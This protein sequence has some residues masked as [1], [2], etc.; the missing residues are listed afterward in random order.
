[1]KLKPSLITSLSPPGRCNAALLCHP[2]PCTV[3][4]LTQAFH[5]HASLF[6]TGP[7]ILALVVRAKNNSLSFCLALSCSFS[8]IIIIWLFLHVC[9]CRRIHFSFSSL[10]GPPCLR[11]G[12][13]LLPARRTRLSRAAT[14]VFFFFFPPNNQTRE[15]GNGEEKSKCQSTWSCVCRG[16]GG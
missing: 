5:F 3:S 12:A 8:P 10:K 13:P 2:C 15:T 14:C 1:M 11:R 16:G 7:T 9:V 4:V 6:I